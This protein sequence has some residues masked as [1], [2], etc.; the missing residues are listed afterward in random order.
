MANTNHIPAPKD[1]K[2]FICADCGAVSLD[3]NNICNVQGKGKKGDWCGVKG[4]P[5]PKTCHTKEHT[6][7]WQCENCGQTAVNPT[8]LCE[9]VKL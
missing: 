5:P 4:S 2:A 8:L 9:P 7:R 1:T 3:A 6:D